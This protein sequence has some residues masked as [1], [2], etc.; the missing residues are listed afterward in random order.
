VS[1]LF[2]VAAMGELV[3][4]LVPEKDDGRAIQFVAYPGG[5]PGNVALGVARL[6]LRAAMLSMVGNESFGESLLTL[7]ND[8][9]VVTSG[10][11]VS[12]RNPT[13]LAVVTVNSERDRE[14]IFVRNGCAD[15][16]YC[17][18]DVPVD[19]VHATRILHVGTRFL[20][21]PAPATA[22]RYAFDLARKSR[23]L[24]SVDANFSSA[25]WPDASFNADCWARSGSTGEYP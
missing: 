25:L 12:D 2:D 18:A 24:I 22:Q 1:K 10:I 11:R 5:A 21:H 3:V 9:G 4:D 20:S 8:G 14:F 17:E 7:L 16:N 19:I 15:L 6:R 13:G 23:A